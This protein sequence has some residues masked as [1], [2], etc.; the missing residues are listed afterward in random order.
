[1]AKGTMPNKGTWVKPGGGQKDP[2]GT[3]IMKGGD[4][5]GRPCKNAGK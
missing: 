4:L 2:S 3:K 5:R 1:M